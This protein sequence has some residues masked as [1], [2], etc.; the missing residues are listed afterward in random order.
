[1]GEGWTWGLSLT[2]LTMAIHATGVVL[3]ALAMMRIRVWL[4]RKSVGLRFVIPIVIGAVAVVGLLLAV[5]HGIEAAAWAAAYLWLGAIAM[6]ADA[7]LYSV[8]AITTAGVSGLTLEEHWRMLS[9]LESADGV[10]LFGISTA[11][12]FAMMQMYWPM[13]S[14]D[15]WDRASIRA[16]GGGGTASK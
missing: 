2:G 11:Y 6:P 14:R 10:L 3:M 15:Q 13:L 1:M 12:L 8:G 5:L 7:M 16:T 4:V 9:A